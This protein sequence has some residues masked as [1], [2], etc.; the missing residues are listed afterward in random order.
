MGGSFSDVK[1]GKQAVELFNRYRGVYPLYTPLECFDGVRTVD[2]FKA[3][4]RYLKADNNANRYCGIC[5][6]TLLQCAVRNRQVD[7]VRLLLSTGADIFKTND[8]HLPLDIA[9]EEGY[10]TIVRL[11]EDHL[12][13]E[14]ENWRLV[15]A[16]RASLDLAYLP[17]SSFSSKPSHAADSHLLPSAPPLPPQLV[18]LEEVSNFHA[19]SSRLSRSSSYIP[20][21][22]DY[23]GRPTPDA[24]NSFTSSVP[25]HG[26]G[27]QPLPSPPLTVPPL[28]ALPE[29]ENTNDEEEERQ[30]AMAIKVSLEP[31]L[32]EGIIPQWSFWLDE[33]IGEAS[34]SSTP[35][36]RGQ[37]TGS[38][39]LSS[40]QQIPNDSSSSRECEYCYD[41]PIKAACDPCGH[42]ACFN[43]WLKIQDSANKCPH[44]RVEIKKIIKLYM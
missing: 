15:M 44:C 1:G 40:A 25:S 21:W 23:W 22:S 16:N 35:L 12:F 14:N 7:V 29:E 19:A 38:Q 4:E 10:H 13:A 2:Q 36:Q 30:V 34:S 37:A 33:P 24:P 5:G 18:V 43:C 9:K 28:A 42:V 27:S 41:A 11:F 20:E 17:S 31:D 3:L 39:S 6:G 8:G 32:K 26:E